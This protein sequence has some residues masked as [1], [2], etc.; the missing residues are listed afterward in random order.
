MANSDLPDVIHSHPVCYEEP[1]GHCEDDGE[2]I[3]FVDDSTAIYSNSD[4]AI[5]SKNLTAHYRN[6]AGY[7]AAN[8]FLINADKTH[9]MVMSPRR[10]AG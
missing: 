7:I 1:T 6:I 4:P 9:V 10:L 8:K 2:S 5:I 3:H